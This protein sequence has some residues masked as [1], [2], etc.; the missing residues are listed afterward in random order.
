MRFAI[1]AQKRDVAKLF[2]R[3][4]AVLVLAGMLLGIPLALASAKVLRSMLYGIEPHDSVT[5]GIT[6]ALFLAAGLIASVLPVRR[7]I[8]IEPLRALRYE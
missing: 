4:S 3:E 2:V 7:A 5:L 6:I 8:R 1:G